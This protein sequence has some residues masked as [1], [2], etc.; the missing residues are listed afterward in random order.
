MRFT[1]V[2]FSLLFSGLVSGT[3]YYSDTYNNI[4]IDAIIN[5][6]RLLNQYTNCIL[7]KGPCTVDGRSLK[8]KCICSLCFISI[9]SDNFTYFSYENYFLMEIRKKKRFGWE[10]KRKNI[11]TEE[12]NWYSY[13]SRNTH[14]HTLRW[15]KSLFIWIDALPDAIATTCERCSEKQK[16]MARKI[17]NYL[18]EHKPNT[19]K[20]FLERYDP[21]K[22]Y[23]ASYEQFLAQAKA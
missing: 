12:N 13:G 3:E 15:I 2:L 11:K 16:Q 10:E 9:Y 4:D 7:D 14:V 8:R 5:N 17:C 22:K 6:A 23:I 20:E 19:W 1:F 18:K 21:D